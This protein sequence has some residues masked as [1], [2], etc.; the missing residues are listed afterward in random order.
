MGESERPSSETEAGEASADVESDPL[1]LFFDLVFVFAFTRVTAFVSHNHSWAGL[2]R[3]VALLA[4]LWWA[5]VTYSWLM[6]TAPT[7]SVLSERVV[8]LTA[9]AV[10]FVVALAVPG[11]FGDT[12]VLF[13]VAYFAV[14]A[15]H[16]GLSV[17]TTHGRARERFLGLVP[18]FLGG[19]ALL[20]AAGFAGEPLR[21]GLWVAG[22]GVDY[23]TLAVGGVAK[24]DV[25]VEHFVERY[26]GIVII[27]LGESI[28]AMGFTV[29]E[30]DPQ[31][32]LRV[33]V[34]AFLGIV[35]VAALG[36]LYFDYVTLAAEEYFVG[37]EGYERGVVARNSY[38][39]LHFPIIA[40]IIFVALGLE[41]T[42]AHVSEP[43][44]VISAVALYGGT[45]LYLLGQNAFRVFDA[46]S[47]SVLRLLVAGAVCLSIPVAAD[48]P[49][50]FAL[51][52]LVVLSIALV[53]VETLYS[54]LRRAVLED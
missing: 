8:I 27:A 35:Y 16:V 43:L 28:L 25:H 21:A 29:A 48:V 45:A 26:R 53:A 54:P 39:Y 37:L 19:P 51:V 34:A 38:A 42:V 2:I 50:L 18:G 52:G 13:G 20:A 41:E 17:R 9:T 33:V 31:L 49:A 30:T 4:A 6:D 3:G 40:G 7:E 44:G 15:L 10:M 22:I 11:A 12:A 47:V 23:G 24:F 32:P 1:E 5:W 36:W 14:R 46:G